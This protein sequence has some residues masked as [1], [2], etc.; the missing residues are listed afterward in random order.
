MWIDLTA[1]IKIE[2][3]EQYKETG[4]VLYASRIEAADPPAEELV[5][6]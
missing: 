2:Y 6:F 3:D 4:P 5:Y 1:Q